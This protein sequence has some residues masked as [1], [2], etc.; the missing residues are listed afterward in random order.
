M[1]KYT[2]RQYVKDL[3]ATNA[4]IAEVVAEL[5]GY[6]ALYDEMHKTG[7]PITD[8]SDKW[9]AAHD[10]KYDLEAELHE[11]EM[12]FMRRNWTWQDHSFAALVAQNID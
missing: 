4:K 10:L 1:T 9:N 3:A 5:A 11:I 2:K 12:K 8:I 7:K 6:D